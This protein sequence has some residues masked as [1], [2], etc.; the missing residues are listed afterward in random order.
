ME[1]ERRG[2]KGRS[3]K[4]MEGK[5]GEW[6]GTEGRVGLNLREGRDDRKVREENG[7]HETEGSAGA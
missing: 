1:R 7:R 4:G 5:K 6:K 3:G 2:R